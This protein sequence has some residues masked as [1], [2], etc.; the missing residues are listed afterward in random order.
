MQSFLL[1]PFLSLITAALFQGI[2]TSSDL[3]FDN[4]DQDEED[5]F[6]RRKEDSSEDTEY[7]IRFVVTR[8]HKH[9]NII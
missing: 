6:P 2:V 7:I 1:L 5:I 4:L 9:L 3:K 8:L